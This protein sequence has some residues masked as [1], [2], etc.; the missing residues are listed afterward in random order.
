MADVQGMLADPQFNAELGQL[1]QMA[2]T[3]PAEQAR[4]FDRIIAR[5]ITGKMTPDDL[6]GEI[7]SRFCIGK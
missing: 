6:L 7:F 2:G 5:E 3:L 4:E 1:R